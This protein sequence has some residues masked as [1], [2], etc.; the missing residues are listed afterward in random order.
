MKIYFKE[1]RLLK[2]E[3]EEIKIK[4]NELIDGQKGNLNQK[5]ADI[6]KKLNSVVPIYRLCAAFDHFYCS[7]IEE[8]DRAIRLGYTYEIVNFY[9]F[10]RNYSN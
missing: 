8:R 7:T 10:P 9:A 6:E 5:I 1:I 3:I 4:N 2:N